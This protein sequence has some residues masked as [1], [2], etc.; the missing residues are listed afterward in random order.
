MRKQNYEL[1][2]KIYNKNTDL[3]L[4]LKTQNYHSQGILKQI[5][6]Y[7]LKTQL[8]FKLPIENYIAN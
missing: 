1:S 7:K 3:L 8:Q 6:H 5:P 4:S 2:N